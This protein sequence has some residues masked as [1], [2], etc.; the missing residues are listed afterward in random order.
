MGKGDEVSKRSPISNSKLKGFRNRIGKGQRFTSVPPCI[1]IDSCPLSFPNSFKSSLI[2]SRIWLQILLSK[3][4]NL[5][6]S[7]RRAGIPLFLLFWLNFFPNEPIF[8]TCFP[9]WTLSVQPKIIS[10]CWGV[11]RLRRRRLE[12]LTCSDGLTHPENLDHGRVKRIRK[13][14]T[15]QTE[16]SCASLPKVTSREFSIS[17]F[18]K[19][20]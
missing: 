5:S 9:I 6:F 1:L 7:L 13:T 19:L 3:V 8:L 20:L 15:L 14:N 2:L 16:S 11:R 4:P 10:L 17:R 12:G 18:P